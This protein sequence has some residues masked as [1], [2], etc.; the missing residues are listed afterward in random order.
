MKIFFPTGVGTPTLM[1]SSPKSTFSY[2]YF[3]LACKQ[4]CFSPRK[5]KNRKKERTK[6]TILVLFYHKSFH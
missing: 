4:L 3:D 1:L 2:S 6:N 5:V